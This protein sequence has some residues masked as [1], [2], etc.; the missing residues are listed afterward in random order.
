MSQLSFTSTKA[1]TSTDIPF[2]RI[3]ASMIMAPSA[4]N[5]Q[6]WKFKPTSNAIEVFIDW[7]RHLKVSDPTLR[8]LYVSIGCAL[9]NASI[10][11]KY[12]GYQADIKYLSADLAGKNK[13]VAR[14]TFSASSIPKNSQS[15]TKLF[16]AIEQRHTDRAIY[17][18]QPLTKE[19]KETLSKGVD[20]SSTILITDRSQVE[21][22]A[23]LSKEGTMRT[24]SRKDFKAE[25]AH[26]V[27]NNWT[28]QH[29]GMPGYAMGIPA[30]LS[31]I[32]PLMVRIIPIHI[33]EA[34]KTKRQAV[35]SSLLAVFVTPSDSYTDWLKAGQS[36]QQVWLNATTAGLTAMPQVAA[37]EAGPDTRTK[38]KQT[39]GTSLFPQSILRIG[40][41]H[42]KPL[43]ATPRRTLDECLI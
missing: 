10:A 40:H 27:R 18:E 21:T 3:I 28:H 16:K 35:S 39:I 31:L 33:Q 23:E 7:N 29:D 15:A 22:I 32:A 8:Q 4:H 36:M 2:K 37:I 14:I 25:L 19:E 17:D 24:L 41:S 38:L 9:T 6:P 20:N 11:A 34:P 43:R 26:W 42:H 5:T 1:K 13:P 30:P 12:W